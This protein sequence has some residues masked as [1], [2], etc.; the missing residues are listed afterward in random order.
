MMTI[1]SSSLMACAIAG[2]ALIGVSPQAAK[3]D[4]II[5][6]VSVTGTGT[7]SNSPSLI[8]DG[9]LP[10]RGTFYQASTNVFST[11]GAPQFTIDLGAVFTV[12]SLIADVDNNDDYVVQYSI[13]NISFNNLF[14]FLASDGPVPVSPGGMEILTT[15]PSYPSV[16]NYPTD[17]TTPVYVGRTFAP[18][19]ARY[20]RI[21]GSGGDGLYAIG[22]LQAFAVPEPTS[23]VMGCLALASLVGFRCIRG[24]SRPVSA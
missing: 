13:N 7:F 2:F 8:I 15:N 19:S 23:L 9:V 18:V 5:P 17:T 16:V 22:E 3:A 11:S 20:L 24:R 4:S 1:R 21:F 6:A 10:P 12:G 14:T